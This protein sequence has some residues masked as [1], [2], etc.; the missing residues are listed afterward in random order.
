MRKLHP[1]RKSFQETY[2]QENKWD[3]L[4]HVHIFQQFRY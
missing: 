2:G 4:F 1:I 3:I